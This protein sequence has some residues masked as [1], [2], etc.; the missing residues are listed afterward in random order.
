MRYA[1]GDVF[2]GQ[3]ANDMKNGPGIYYYA[4]G[5][6]YEGV[7]QE[8]IAKCGC[9]R[10][11]ADTKDQQS[12]TLPALQLK[13]ADQVVQDAENSLPCGVSLKRFGAAT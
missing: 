1:N 8:D 5:A 10:R 9:Y 7:W 2:E 6:V 4:Q 11:A 13:D 3:W 12:G